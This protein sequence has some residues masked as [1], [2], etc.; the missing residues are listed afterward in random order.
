MPELLASCVLV[1]II[2]QWLPTTDPVLRPIVKHCL[3]WNA[4]DCWLWTTYCQLFLITV[5]D[6]ESST[7]SIHQP[8]P[9]THR[10]QTSINPCLSTTSTANYVNHY[11]LVTMLL[12]IVTE[13]IINHFQPSLWTTPPD[14]LPARNNPWSPATATQQSSPGGQCWASTSTMTDHESHD[15]TVSTTQEPPPRLASTSH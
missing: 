15:G 9:T 10:D 8:L 5:D 2:N 12:V 1:I 6:H 11:Q 14:A 13:I 3:P 7:L 4:I